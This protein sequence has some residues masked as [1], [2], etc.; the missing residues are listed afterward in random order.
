MTSWFLFSFPL[1]VNLS[2]YGFHACSNIW[3][4]P[5]LGQIVSCFFRIFYIVF[6]GRVV[7]GAGLLIWILV[8]LVFFFIVRLRGKVW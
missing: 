8:S 6:G 2:L 5:D 7:F 4:P 1:P 3:F